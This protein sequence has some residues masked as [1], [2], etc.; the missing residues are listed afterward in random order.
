M[1][2]F[3]FYDKFGFHSQCLIRFFMIKLVPFVSFWFEMSDYDFHD[4]FLF[5]LVLV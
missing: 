2:H 5:C 1:T 3:C 4:E